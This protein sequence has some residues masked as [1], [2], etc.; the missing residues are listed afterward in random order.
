MRACVQRVTSASVT[1]E[2]EIVGR[3]S[4]GLLVLLGVADGDT[5]AD[6]E[7]L[8]DK[9][10]ELRIFGDEAGKMN[11]SLLDVV[12]QSLDDAAA[13]MLVV[14]QFT[15]LGDCRKGRRPS[16]IAAA[17]PEL[18]EALYLQFVERARRRGLRVE[19]GKFRAHMDVAL[20]N[21]GPV[22]ILLDSRKL[23]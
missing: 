12:Q 10:V 5:A 18:G 9:I 8:A 22:T 4:G 14:S 11:R 21:D 1:V 15:L 6:A 17:T 3:I 13:G 23:F 19:T 20:V 16:F 7:Q 2:G